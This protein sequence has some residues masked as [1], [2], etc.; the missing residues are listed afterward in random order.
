LTVSLNNICF[1]CCYYCRNAR[2]GGYGLD[3]A[4][5]G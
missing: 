1:S 2:C 3:R 4:G 5:S